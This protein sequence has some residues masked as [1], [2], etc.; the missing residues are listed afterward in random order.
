MAL[1]QT[2]SWHSVGQGPADTLSQTTL[3]NAALLGQPCHPSR[4]NCSSCSTA[5]RNHSKLLMMSLLND[6]CTNG[7]RSNEQSEQVLVEFTQLGR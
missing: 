7:Q 1:C 6:H 5:F 4:S 2:V 3:L